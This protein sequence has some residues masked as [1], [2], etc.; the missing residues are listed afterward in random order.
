MS[1]I[2]LMGAVM[3]AASSLTSVQAQENRG[4]AAAFQ[5]IARQA[6]VQPASHAGVAVDESGAVLGGAA[7]PRLNAPL[8]PSPVQSIQ[9]WSGGTIITN[10]ALAPHEMLYPHKYHAMYPPFYYR[11]KGCWVWTPFGMR[12]HEQW[13]LQGTEV[14]VNYRSTYAPFSGFHPRH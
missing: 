11:V 13:K 5:T 4:H 9:P 10:Q 7:Y 2:A 6:P 8:Y 12:Q 14:K 3:L 1:R